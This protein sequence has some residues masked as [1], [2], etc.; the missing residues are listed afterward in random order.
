MLKTRSGFTIVELLIVIVV[1]AILAAI[2][3]VAYNGV[4]QRARDSAASQLTSQ[5]GR[6][7]L[8]YQ[9]LNGSYPPDLAS[10][11]I[12][13]TS[14]LQYSVTT[15][16]T[17]TFCVTG[18]NGNS[19]FYLNNS[20]AT[21]PTKGGCAGHGQGGVAA[22]TNLHP[23]PGAINFTGYGSWAGNTGNTITTAVVA[24]PW[25][26]SGSAYRS[27]WTAVTNSTG[28]LQVFLNSGSPL[29][30]N[31]TYTLRYRVMANQN[32][33]IG[34]P[35]LYASAGT[36]TT[37]ARSHSGDITLTAGVPVDIWLTFQG[38]ATAL[39]S[40]FRV[41]L[42]PRNLAA[43][44]SFELSE[45]VVYAGA[46]NTAIGFVWGNS[47]NWVWNGA[48]NASTSTGPV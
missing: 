37:I 44:N 8:A 9:A 45:A 32:G 22:V 47:T 4:Q 26:G 31:T 7:I 15:S 14:N 12:A 11:D 1:I 3:I 17:P 5:A 42:N 30:A 34:A 33:T 10:A 25:S 28:D 20:T 38:D 36:T 39:T 19:S 40:G 41:L 2:S 6:K 43:N 23:N 29:S 27:T 35:G 48:Q 13:D 24:A 21:A 46:R 18:T 16:G